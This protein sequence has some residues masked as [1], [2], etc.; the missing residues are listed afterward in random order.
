M[1]R[2]GIAVNLHYIPVYR[3]PYFESLGFKLGYCKNA[4]QYYKETI[5]LPMY[6]SLSSSDQDKVINILKAG[7]N[8]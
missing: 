5:S 6:P 8:L 3:Q 7:L 4:E 2:S 1:R